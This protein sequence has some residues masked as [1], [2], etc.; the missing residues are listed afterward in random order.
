MQRNVISVSDKENDKVISPFEDKKER[1]KFYLVYSNSC[2]HAC[3]FARMHARMHACARTHTH[4]HTH[5][6]TDTDTHIFIY[7][8]TQTHTDMYKSMKHDLFTLHGKTISVF[9]ISNEHLL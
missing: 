5:T 2:L 8:H 1:G 4:T 3:M 9:L 6:H 7:I